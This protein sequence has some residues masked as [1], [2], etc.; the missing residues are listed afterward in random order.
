MAEILF[1]LKFLVDFVFADPILKHFN[2]ISD[3]FFKCIRFPMLLIDRTVLLE[4][5]RPFQPDLL[6]LIY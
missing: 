4:I 5:G 1:Q 2:G 3:F 6:C